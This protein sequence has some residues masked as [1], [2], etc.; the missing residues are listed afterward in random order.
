MV[1]PT[2]T[3]LHLARKN[4]QKKTFFL[5]PNG[6][7]CL[8]KNDKEKQLANC[9]RDF[10]TL[11]FG[12]YSECISYLEDNEA[13]IERKDKRVLENAKRFNNQYIDYFDISLLPQSKIE[14]KRLLSLYDGSREYINIAEKRRNLLVDCFR[15][16][17]LY[18]IEDARW[19]IIRELIDR[20]VGVSTWYA[21]EIM[22]KEM[23]SSNRVID[24]WEASTVS[25]TKLKRGNTAFEGLVLRKG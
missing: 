11:E 6:K 1:V 22:W 18:Q 16:Q 12:L 15:T 10:A 7:S 4:T 9:I 19:R 24:L 8:Y 25:N 14:S 3:R 21:D 17:Q 20:G 2:T 23:N 5:S 13:E